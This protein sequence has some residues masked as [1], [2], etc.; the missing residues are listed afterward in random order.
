LSLTL[1]E[2]QGA[3]ISFRNSEKGADEALQ[4]ANTIPVF[5]NSEQRTARAV[6]DANTTFRNSEQRTAQAVHEANTTFRKSEQ[7]TSLCLN[8][9]DG[10]TLLLK[11]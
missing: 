4:D 6:Q 10:Y 1:S 3:R 9:G 5:R 2:E 7:V 11:H 8:I